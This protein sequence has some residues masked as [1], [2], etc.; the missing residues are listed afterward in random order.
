MKKDVPIPVIRR[1]NISET[2]VHEI[3]ALVMKEYF[4]P[5]EKLPSEREL[6]ERFK[7]GRY[8]LREGLRALEAK[9]LINVMPGKGIFVNLPSNQDF[10]NALTSMFILEK[11]SLEELIETRKLIES[12]A[13]KLAAERA[14]AQDL[15][16]IAAS[17]EQLK[18]AGNNREKL[19]DADE[20][21]H[22]SIAIA[23]HNTIFE[24][25]TK[26]VRHA[27]H[28]AVQRKILDISEIFNVNTS[29]VKTP[30]PAE[31]CEQNLSYHHGIYEAVRNHNPNAAY[32]AMAE[33]ISKGLL[34][35]YLEQKLKEKEGNLDV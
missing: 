24:K 8:T 22:F 6:A 29:G 30:Y 15:E 35:R 31:F 7:V 10:T 11:E 5:G 18:L 16:A 26:A 3:E 12:E 14:T 23:T 13:A 27:M 21:F 2:V 17:Y 1:Q 25:V 9:G 20:Q 32:D 4:K 28:E 19:H 34:I 33:H